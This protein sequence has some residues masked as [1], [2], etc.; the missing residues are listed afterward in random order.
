[1]TSSHNLLPRLKFLS[2]FLML[3]L[4]NGKIALA[5]ST[6]TTA[7]AVTVA[8]SSSTSISTNT[9]VTLTA[10]VTTA[11]TP[12]SPGQ[13]Y[14]CNASAPSCSATS[15]L[16]IAQLTSAGTATYKYIPSPGSHSY[17]AVFAGTHNYAS[18]TSAAS[19]AITV[20][21]PTHTSILASSS[22]PSTLT[23]T[24]YGNGTK[25]PTGSVSFIDQSNGNSI[26]A[27]PS[28]VANAPAYNLLSPLASGASVNGELSE[29]VAIAD[30]NGDGIPDIFLACS[31]GGKGQVFFGQGDGTFKESTAG[32]VAISCQT[33]SPMSAVVADVNGDGYPD[34]V[35]GG[36]DGATVLLNDSKGNFTPT[37]S[38]AGSFAGNI[39]IADLNGDGIPDLVAFQLG[40]SELIVALGDGTGNFTAQSPIYANVSDVTVGDFNG[41]GIPDIATTNYSAATVTLLL[42]VGDGTFTATSPITLP[43]GLQPIAITSG[44]LNN[45]GKLDIAVADDG[46]SSYSTAVLLFGDGKGA[47]SSPYSLPNTILYDGAYSMAINAV[48]LNGDGNLDILVGASTSDTGGTVAVFSGNGEGIFTLATSTQTDFVYADIT[49]T[50]YF[51][52]GDVNGDGLPDVVAPVGALLLSSTQSATA[53]A[54]GVNT[55]P[56]QGAYSSTAVATYSGD[57]NYLTGTAQSPLTLYSSPTAVQVI[58][59]ISANPAAAGSSQTLTATVIGSEN[60]PTG[61]VN[62]FNGTTPLGTGTLTNGVATLTITAPAVGSYSLTASY[63]GDSYYSAGTSQVLAL[64]TVNIA[65]PS[66]TL[67]A[68]P[69]SPAYGTPLTLTATVSGSNGIATGTVNFLNGATSLGTATLN[70]TGSASITLSGPSGLPQGSYSFSAQYSGNAEYGAT[71]AT[72][73]TVTVGAPLPAANVRLAVTAAGAPPTSIAVFTPVTLTATVTNAGSPVTPGEVYFCNAIE[74]AC[75]YTNKLAAAQLTSAGTATFSLVPGP[76]SHSYVAVFAGT[77]SLSISTSSASASF[78]VTGITPHTNSLLSISGNPGSYTMNNTVYATGST[79]PTG[80]TSFTVTGVSGNTTTV[81]AVS[82]P[83]VSNGPSYNLLPY[84][85]SGINS[86]SSPFLYADFNGDGIPDVLTQNGV[87]ATVNFGVGGG[88][89]SGSGNTFST[90]GEPVNGIAADVNNDGFP[91]IILSYLIRAQTYTYGFVVFLNDG[92]GN[93]TAVPA[94]VTVPAEIQQLATADFNEDGN[95]DLAYV[96]NGTMTI[97]LGDGTGNFTPG[98]PFP[99]AIPILNY[100]FSGIYMS[101]ADM[102]NDGI[103]DIITANPDTQTVTVYLGIGDG[104]FSSAPITYTNASLAIYYFKFTTGDFNNDGNIDVALVNDTTNCTGCTNIPY[105]VNILWGNGAGGFTSLT[106]IPYPTGT[107]NP[108]DL[109]AADINGDG[110]MDIISAN[111]ASYLFMGT[112]S[113]TFQVA[114]AASTTAFGSPTNL[115]ALDLNGDGL[116]DIPGFLSS[117]IS[118]TATAV[119]DLPPSSGAYTIQSSYPGDKN[120][121]AST[122]SYYNSIY[123]ATTTPTVTL[124]GPSS[125]VAL[126]TKYNFVFVVSVTGVGATPPGGTVGI[127]SGSTLLYEEDLPLSGNDVITIPIQFPT[128]GTYTYTAVYSGD[129]NYNSATSAPLSITASSAGTAT[130]TAL[131]VTA[132]GSPVTSV[133]S[134]TAV[135]L[136]ATVTSGGSPAPLGTVYF[137]TY[138][139]EF[140]CSANYN[141][142]AAQLSAAG[143]ASWTFIPGPGSH[144]YIAAYGGKSGYGASSSAASS[145]LTVTGKPHTFASLAVSGTSADYTLNATVYGSASSAPS[146]SVSILGYPVGQSSKLTTLATGTLVPP[147]YPS[148]FAVTGVNVPGSVLADFNRDG[149]PDTFVLS[150]VAQPSSGQCGSGAQAYNLVGQLSTGNGD[151]TFTTTASSVTLPCGSSNPI[152]A[153]MNN[154]GYLDIVLDG[155]YSGTPSFTILL[156]DGTGKFTVHTASPSALAS[157]T[158]GQIAIADF[159]HDGN[160]DVAI[161]NAS[162]VQIGLGNGAGSAT[163]LSAGQPTGANLTSFAIGDI[164][165]DGYPDIAAVNP[166]AQTAPIFYG[167]GNGTFTAKTP[168]TPPAD[169]YP[170]GNSILIADA[171]NDGVPD[172]VISSLQYNAIV[173]YFNDGQGGFNTRYPPDPAF[174]QGFAPTTA[175]IG[176]ADLNGDGYMDLFI[177][178]NTGSGNEF[179]YLNGLGFTDYDYEFDFGYALYPVPGNAPVT[180]NTPLTVIDANGDGALDVFYPGT[181]MLDSTQLSTVT[182]SSFTLPPSSGNYYVYPSYAGDSNYL[183]SIGI[184]PILLASATS[185]VTLTGPVSPAATNT[186]LPFSITV[187]GTGATPTG[188]VSLYN[189]STLLGSATLSGGAATI[190][191]TFTTPGTYSFTATYSGDTNYSAATSQPFSVTAITKKPATVI[192][193]EFSRATSYGVPTQLIVTVAGG[194]GGVFPTGTVTYSLG[195]ITL[196]TATVQSNTQ[197]S[198]TVPAGRIPAGTATITVSYSGDAN[199]APSTGTGTVTLTKAQPTLALTASSGTASSVSPVTFTARLTYTGAAPTGAVTLYDGST[200]ITS[201]TPTNGVVTYADSTLSPGTHS[202]T[203]VYAGDANYNSATS[204]AVSVFAL[205]TASI[206]TS[207]ISKTYIYGPPDKLVITVAGG[208]GGVFPTG[209]VTFAIG[210]TALGTTTV[211]SNTQA[212]LTVPANKLPDGASTITISYSGDSNF[213]SATAT[214]TVT[215]SY[216]QPTLALTSSASTAFGGAPITFTAKLTYTGSGATP[217]DPITLYDGATA[218][219]SITPIN[220]VITFSDSTLSA[221][222]HSITASYAGDAYYAAATSSPVSVTINKGTVTVDTAEMTH[223]TFTYNPN[224]GTTPFTVSVYGSTHDVFPT[225]TL[226]FTT[227]SGLVLGQSQVKNNAPSTTSVFNPFLTIGF[228]TINVSYSGDSN[229][230]SATTTVVVL[231]QTQTATNLTFSTNT[232]APNTLVYIYGVPITM[233]ATVSSTDTTPLTGLITFY[234]GATVLS[235]T[236]IPANN[237]TTTYTATYTNSTLTVGSHNLS[238]TYT[239]DPR[240]LSAN[241]G[242]SLV[243][244]KKTTDSIVTSEFSKAFTYGSPITLVV[245]IAGGSGGVFP[246]GIVTFADSTAT[247]GTVNVMSNTQAALTLPAGTLQAGTT[248]IRVSYLGDVNFP[249]AFVVAPITLAKEPTSPTLTSSTTSATAGSPVSFSVTMSPP[250]SSLNGEV[251]LYDGANVLYALNGDSGYTTSG[252][253]VGTH[254]I[255]AV[256]TVFTFVPQNYLNSTSTPIIVTI[257]APPTSSKSK[258]K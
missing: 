81:P 35:T 3:V 48:D 250:D 137:C 50:S 13:V 189:G 42:G 117:S 211:M 130:A 176:A 59:A 138:D 253:A 34:I 32:P 86:N 186:P 94:S 60:T 224:T 121:S 252:L 112:G 207:E 151:G 142:A 5:A 88:T 40:G 39:R 46:I 33:I 180:S 134:G 219:T 53:T 107:P 241:S 103:P 4:V 222:T 226:T 141:L 79:A 23:S 247:L 25:V 209:T 36:Y 200:A 167:V 179:I 169:F 26:L 198:L 203:A 135:T 65:T 245:T 154:D 71:S 54:T 202:I 145:V 63:P 191:Y 72:P 105:A 51:A 61:T 139:V 230:P 195:S 20:A 66:V 163:F 187:S 38:T 127:Y 30:L 248:Q 73:L 75:N 175:T 84:T 131:T 185:T 223:S 152:V 204:S 183:G 196:G 172:L 70:S 184:A 108:G 220:G 221:G 1:M 214:A 91:D 201:L 111:S 177:F 47:F 173:L 85:G 237:S 133:P 110:K 210:S 6:T 166:T 100:S 56:I 9:A 118:S 123:A 199:F 188:S 168:F 164:N 256:Y 68:S 194:S 254:S 99:T 2:A 213:T 95:V 90:V 244:I 120:Y 156:N 208:S 114:N 238:F 52:V 76:G 93:F 161:L 227:T 78:T 181:L 126:N 18:S 113:G 102:N 197:A 231:L 43:T 228:N 157:S 251:S 240:N 232:T 97:A 119:P 243:Q 249:S 132:A 98:N 212:A 67:T 148:G 41:D 239:N 44:D 87:T 235:S 144:T 16:A 215:A 236:T 82:A 101:V 10:T 140:S 45:D 80:D 15:N 31:T 162:G 160:L 246:T 83:L 242:A 129:N 192:T 150:T 24:V 257:T 155:A 28:L 171:N 11:G 143:A 96:I 206:L 109:L 17:T 8:G 116:L 29:A 205:R 234:D 69:T 170:F 37:P 218:I 193:S 104:T 128:A 258:T 49:A 217:T 147:T 64:T 62:F 233:T 22:G 124:T 14:F 21:G 146:G 174:I 19:A 7:L 190:P 255:T 27:Q 178:G 149:V 115:V 153:D 55:P 57:T 122:A 165:S 158:P 225:G 58:L 159:N 74:P 106:S 92:K 182:F 89:Y 136:T 229:Y 77:K 216:V 125:P 12:V